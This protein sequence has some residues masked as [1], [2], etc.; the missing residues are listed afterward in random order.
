MRRR[1]RGRARRRIAAPT[2][3]IGSTI[4]QVAHDAFAESRETPHS[5]RS[6]S[7]RASAPARSTGT[8]PTR[9]ALI[10]AVYQH[11]MRRLVDSVPDVAGRA[12]PT[13][14]LQAWFQHP[15]RLRPRQ[16]RPRRGAAH[17]GGQGR[18]QRHLGAGHRRGFHAPRR[19]CRRRQVRAGLDPGDVLLLMGFLWRV[20]DGPSGRQQADRMMAIVVDGLRPAEIT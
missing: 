18:D 1:P 6:P 5:M 15:G 19:V 8:I 2:R 7:A 20:P 12:R 13:R 11:D 4:L 14:R 10:L 16:A 9:E 17:G 3:R